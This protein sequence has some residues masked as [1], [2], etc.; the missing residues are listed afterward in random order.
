M[1]PLQQNEGLSIGHVLTF[2]SITDLLLLYSLE[3]CLK[4]IPCRIFINSFPSVSRTLLVCDS[5]RRKEPLS[6]R[7]YGTLTLNHQGKQPWARVF[8]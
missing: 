6:E 1:V 2:S 7:L 4:G 8:I 3:K 5:P